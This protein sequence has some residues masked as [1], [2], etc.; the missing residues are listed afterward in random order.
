MTMIK[1]IFEHANHKFDGKVVVCTKSV[2]FY[3]VGEIYKY[4]KDRHSNMIL[5]M[6]NADGFWI[7]SGLNGYGGEFRVVEEEKQLSFKFS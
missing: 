6:K 7:Y 1:P 2:N 5:H 3:V 4:V